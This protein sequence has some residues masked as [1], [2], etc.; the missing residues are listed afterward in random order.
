M[1]PIIKWVGGKTQLL[2]DIKKNLPSDYNRYIEPFLGGGSVLLFLAPKSALVNDL[3]SELINMYKVVRNYPKNL[4]KLL[5]H[6]DENISEDY[7]Y[8]IRSLDNLVGLKN[9]SHIYRASRFV[10]LN[11]AG[12]NG[13]YRVNSKGLMNVPFGQ[14][15]KLNSYDKENLE[16]VSNYFRKENINFFNQDYKQFLLNNTKNNDFIYLDPP[17]DPIDDTSSF[18]AYQ[19][20]GFGREEQKSLRDLCVELHNKGAKIMISNSN[21]TFINE[22][23]NEYHG[24]FNIKIVYARRSINS[25]GKKRGEVEEVIIRNY[26]GNSYE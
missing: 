16:M 11:K 22:L 4:M 8:K 18:V 13:L 9:L 21:T 6:H 20:N 23:Y 1:K 10:F 12:F 19:K 7:Y 5:D 24:I 26:G 14:K 3:N 15:E 17:Y 25:N 2:N